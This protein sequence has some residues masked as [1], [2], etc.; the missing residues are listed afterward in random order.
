LH[1]QDDDLDASTKYH[2]FSGCIRT[3]ASTDLTPSYDR[4]H[5]KVVKCILA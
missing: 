4:A 1:Q 5:L 3:L 2:E